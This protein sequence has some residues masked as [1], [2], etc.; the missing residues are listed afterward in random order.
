MNVSKPENTKSDHQQIN[1]IAGQ[2][3]HISTFRIL[4][5]RFLSISKSSFLLDALLISEPFAAWKRVSCA[6]ANR[7]PWRTALP[8]FER[9]AAW[10]HDNWASANRTSCSIELPIIEHFETWIRDYWVSTNQHPCVKALPISLLF[11]N[12]NTRV[13]SIWKSLPL[14]D[15]TSLFRT[16]RDWW[17]SA[18]QPHCLRGPPIY[19]RL[20]S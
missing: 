4:K 3:Y 17:A 7:P 6:V 2:L 20:A 13:L 1:L 19:Q 11:T 10:K 14:R 16:F 5:T 8:I 9:F 12:L 18:I 15:G